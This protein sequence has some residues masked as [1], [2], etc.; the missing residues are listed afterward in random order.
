MQIEPAALADIPAL[1]QLLEQLFEQEA[2]FT[3]DLDAQRRGLQM[4]LADGA[5]GMILVARD[6]QQIVGMVNLLYTVSTALGA[7]VALLEDMVIAP[8]E[9]N[10]GLG[11]RLLD[12]A[13]GYAKQNGCRR[14]TLLTD[15][16]NLSAQRFY[17]RQGFC[18]SPMIPL[19]LPLS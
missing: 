19:R 15:A 16:D 14:I 12:A 9:R 18:L 4:I 8:N 17:Q 6:G 13:V 11:T 1:C 10:C 5:T 3:P 7:R 2:E